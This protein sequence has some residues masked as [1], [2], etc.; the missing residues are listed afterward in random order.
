[1]TELNVNSLKDFV[2]WNLFDT[3]D[4]ISENLMK[5]FNLEKKDIKFEKV[6]GVDVIKII[7]PIESINIS[8]TVKEGDLC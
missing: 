5:E 4:N 7:T 1:M 6:N 2:R 8:I 3:I